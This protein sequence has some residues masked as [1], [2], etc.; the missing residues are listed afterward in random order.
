MSARSPFRD[1]KASPEVICLAV[2]LYVRFPLLLRNVEE[3]LQGR[4][5]EVS[6]GTVRNR[7]LGFGSMLAAEIWKKR[8]GAMHSSRSRGHLDKVV[9]TVNR[10]STTYGVPWTMTARCLKS[11]SRRR[12][13][14]LRHSSSSRS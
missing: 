13:T 11:P 6:H 5:I 2:V 12:R 10:A 7:W 1:F 14:R 4:G 9:V 3:L 8:G